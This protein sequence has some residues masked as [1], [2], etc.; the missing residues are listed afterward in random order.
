ESNKEITGDA[1]KELYEKARKYLKDVFESVRLEKTISLNPGIQ[2]IND[3]IALQSSKDTL[4][5][6]T[7]QYD[8][9]DEFVVT[10]PVN[11]AIYAIRMAEH[12]GWR[13]DRQ[14][15]LGMA[16]LL[17]DVGMASIPDELLFKEGRLSDAECRII[18]ERSNYAYNI[19]KT[20][21]DDYAYLA[22]C[23]LH[24]NERL[25]GS[26]YPMGLKGDEISEIAQIIGLVDVYEALIHSRPQREKLP[27]FTAIKE[28]IKLGKNIFQKQYLKTLLNIFSR[29]PIFSYVRLNSNAIGRV[30]ETY[31]G[32]PVSPKVQIVFD[33]ENRRLL[34]ER[35]INLQENPQFTIVDS[36]SEEELNGLFEK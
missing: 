36:V 20:F 33:S 26:G 4:F 18:K 1:G 19:L 28:I 10:H 17:H 6:R 21:K 3:M 13:K 5:L 31:P 35:I 15:D 22:E 2:I 34:T 12:L 25:D 29:F 9:L 24:V 16:A 7:F 30:I 8:D 23:A 14:V 11:V 32:Q 27:H